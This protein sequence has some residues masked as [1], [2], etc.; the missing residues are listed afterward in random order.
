MERVLQR[1]A[2]KLQ[3]VYRKKLNLYVEVEP[4]E[5]LMKNSIM[6]STF[7][8][9]S[10][11]KTSRSTVVQA[12]MKGEHD[13]KINSVRNEQQK[14]EFNNNKSEVDKLFSV[15]KLVNIKRIN[16]RWIGFAE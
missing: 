15:P 7:D 3:N 8:P 6:I 1:T 11:R 13:E 5:L 12:I 10:K 2:K 16:N 14:T 4:V 9:Q